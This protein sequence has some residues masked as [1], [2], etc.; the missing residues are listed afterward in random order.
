M[1]CISLIRTFYLSE[2]FFGNLSN[3][4]WITENALY[5]NNNNILE[6]IKCDVV[7]MIDHDVPV[8]RYGNKVGMSS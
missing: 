3:G 7:M 1:I 4:V 8:K 5:I 2:L 6:K